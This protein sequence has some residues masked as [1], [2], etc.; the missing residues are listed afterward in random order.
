MTKVKLIDD[1]LKSQ[2][3][4][5]NSQNKKTKSIEMDDKLFEIAKRKRFIEKNEDGYF[6]IGDYEDLL[7]FKTKRNPKN[8]KC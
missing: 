7:A 2:T 5:K 1:C 3:E 8:F 4:D 6:F